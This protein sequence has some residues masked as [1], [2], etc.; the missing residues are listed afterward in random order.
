MEKPKAIIT[1]KYMGKITEKAWHNIDCIPERISEKEC[2]SDNVVVENAHGD[3]I[4][5]YYSY[6]T[7]KW[8]SDF[9]RK[10]MYPVQ[11]CYINDG[12]NEI[13]FT[14]SVMEYGDDIVV[15]YV[16]LLIGNEEADLEDEYYQ[17][18]ILRDALLCSI[19]DVKNSQEFHLGDEDSQGIASVEDYLNMR[20]EELLEEIGRI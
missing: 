20:L 13:L 4:E 2:F 18:M 14:D 3:I 10:R 19:N 5:A 6:L 8:Y 15:E 17:N 12:S 16:G 1:K 9:D 7:N 11:W